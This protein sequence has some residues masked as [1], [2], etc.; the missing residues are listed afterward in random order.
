M[1]ITGEI[2]DATIEKLKKEKQFENW[3]DERFSRLRVILTTKTLGSDE[4]IEKIGDALL[5]LITEGDEKNN[6][7]DNQDNGTH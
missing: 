1:D 6:E 4:D 7:Q 2:A 5:E 3:S